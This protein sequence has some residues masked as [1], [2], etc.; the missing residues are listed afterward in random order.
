MTKCREGGSFSAQHSPIFLKYTGVFPRKFVFPTHKNLSPPCTSLF[1]KQAPGRG[2][3]N[4]V[5]PSAV[6][7]A[8]VCLILLALC[9]QGC[10]VRTKNSRKISLRGVPRSF[11]GVAGFQDKK[12]AEVK[13]P[14]ISSRCFPQH[15][16]SAARENLTGFDSP[17]LSRTAP[18]RTRLQR[19][20]F[21]VLRLAVLAGRQPA[22]VRQAA[23]LER[24]SVSGSQKFCRSASGPGKTAGNPLWIAED[25]NAA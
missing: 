8:R 25:F 6:L 18:I 9:Q 15:W 21:G 23:P 13:Y 16:R 22:C 2:G 24:S 3:S 10:A 4:P 19:R 7:F 14:L 5:S 1:F 12:N 17:L 20:Y 11:P